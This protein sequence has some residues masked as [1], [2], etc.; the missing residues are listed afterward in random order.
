MGDRHLKIYEPRDNSSRPTGSPSYEGVVERTM[1]EQTTGLEPAT[2]TLARRRVIRL[3]TV[4]PVTWG[5][6]SPS[7]AEPSIP[8]CRGALYFLEVA[9]IALTKWLR[10]EERRWRSVSGSSGI[11]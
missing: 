11:T 3:V 6:S 7:A 2:L 9:T 8:P 5:F 4:R 10:W 1:V